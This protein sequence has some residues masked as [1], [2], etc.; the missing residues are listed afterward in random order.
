MSQNLSILSLAVVA[1][2]AI[3]A[4]RFVTESGAPSGAGGRALGVAR[5]AGAIG[6]AVAVDVVG[7]AQVE[8]GGVVAKGAKVQ[9]D[10][11][12]KA[13]AVVSADKSFIA[14]GGDA[15]DITATGI[16]TDHVLKHVINLTD[17]T[18]VT[19]EFT[20]ADDDTINND[21]GTAT[22]GDDLLVIWETSVTG[23]A[24]EAGGDGDIIEVLLV[25]N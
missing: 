4:K 8:A 9:P 2:A 6:E 18:D 1:T 7:T 21:G 17:G 23:R 14:A 15:G 11:D 25:A 5:Q 3:T 22:T 12:G 20:I 19:S 13:V 16:T 10:A 24:L